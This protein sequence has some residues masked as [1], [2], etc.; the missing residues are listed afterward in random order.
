MIV[1]TI[2]RVKVKKMWFVGYIL[3]IKLVKEHGEK[4]IRDEFGRI[5]GAVSD[6]SYRT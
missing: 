3:C 6:I 5:V 4:I 2:E 1:Y